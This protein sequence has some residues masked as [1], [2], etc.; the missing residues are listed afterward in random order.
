MFFARIS[1]G[2]ERAISRMVHELKKKELNELR[3]DL[4]MAFKEESLRNIK[5]SFS[6]SYAFK[7]SELNVIKF[8]FRRKKKK[9]ALIGF[10]LKKMNC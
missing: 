4:K 7:M 6:V 3:N 1:L 9:F 5:I 10:E 2:L 8:L